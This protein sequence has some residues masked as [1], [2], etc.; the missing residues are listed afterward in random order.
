MIPV[1]P[2]LAGEAVVQTR[3]AAVETAPVEGAG[4]KT[5]AVKSTKSA[6]VEAAAVETPSATV[7]TPSTAVETPSTAVPS[8]P[9]RV[10]EIRLAENSRAQQCGCNAQDRPRLARPGFAIA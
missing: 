10:G 6:A 7:E 4:V 8:T 2:A 5:T 1:P 3:E 9:V